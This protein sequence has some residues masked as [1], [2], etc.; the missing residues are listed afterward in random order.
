LKGGLDLETALARA[1]ASG[2]FLGVAVNAGQGFPVATD[3]AAV[4]FVDSMKGKPVFVGMQGEGREWVTLLSK[5]TRA[6]FDYVFSDALTFTNPAG[7]R[8]HLWVPE[9]V[10]IGPDPE[11]FMDLVV[12]KTVGVLK[13]PIDFLANPTFLPAALVPRYDALWTEAR[14]TRVIEAAVANGVAV[15][16][17]GRYKIPSERFLRL[18]KAKGVKFTFGTNNAGAADFGDWS[19][20]LAMQKALGLTG[21]DMFVPGHA[22]SRARRE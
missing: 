15:E 3:A 16:I 17:N 11:A 5:E 7:K 20:P 8:M 14:M 6:R 12:E 1:R 9:E 2:I 22:P 19:Y 10:D 21:K 4:A 13:E 18:A